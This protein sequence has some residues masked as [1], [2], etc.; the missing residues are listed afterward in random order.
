MIKN[1]FLNILKL[2]GF[3]VNDE[4][5]LLFVTLLLV[6]LLLLLLLLLRENG[7]EL[8]PDKELPDALPA[9]VF[10]RFFGLPIACN[11]VSFASL[12]LISSI[13]KRC[14]SLAR[15]LIAI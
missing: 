7:L 8:M 11:A 5:K 12:C 10:N 2:T 6:E 13:S 4:N 9:D 1:F 14:I 3:E 15:A